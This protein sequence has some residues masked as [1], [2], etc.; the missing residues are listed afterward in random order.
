MF[1]PVK[2]VP[3]NRALSMFAPSRFALV[4]ALPLRSICRKSI[5]SLTAV[6]RQ[7][8]KV[9]KYPAYNVCFELCVFKV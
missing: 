4:N 8:V 2:F 7:S 5:F 6:S 9:L 1:A 3:V